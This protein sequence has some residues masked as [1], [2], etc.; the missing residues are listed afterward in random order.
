MVF[1]LD[2]VITN[3]LSSLNHVTFERG[4]ALATSVGAVSYKEC[5]ALQNDGVRDV[6]EFAASFVDDAKLAKKE[7]TLKC[8]LPW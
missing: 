5:S 3:K 7:K 1:R 8:C 6:F 2:K 4:Q